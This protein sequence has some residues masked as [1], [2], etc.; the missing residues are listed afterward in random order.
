MEFRVLNYFL[1]VTREA[2]IYKAAESLHVTQPTISRQL[3]DLES[4]LNTKLF[5]RGKRKITL[6]KS[7]QLLR[8]RA[9]EIASLMEKTRQ[10]ITQ[11][12]NLVSG[13]IYLGC[14]ESDSFNILAKTAKKLQT[15]YQH[16]CYHLFSGNAIEVTDR[17][18]K[19]LLDFGLLIEP[20]NFRQYNYIKLPCTDTWG[21]LMRSDSELAGKSTITP[22]DL[23]DLPL[24]ISI[25]ALE[26]NELGNYLKRDYSMLNI[27][28][29]Y[30]LVYN[31]SIMVKEGLGYALTLD[32]L[33]NT[34]SD[35]QLCFRPLN[36]SV[37]ASLYLIWKKH[38][39]FSQPAEL[40]LDTI[41]REYT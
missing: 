7:G 32:K 23:W 9:E 11:V 28:A 19:G 8:K 4:E 33:I 38:Q 24:I 37:E 36:P 25:Q 5:I 20:S 6:T 12:D 15:Q 22:E 1:A 3:M 17:L 30:N 29:T 31:A 14:G 34:N 21:V 2:N 41:R 35:S 40:F 10:E 18:D 26:T 13:D 27:S 16:I 39:L